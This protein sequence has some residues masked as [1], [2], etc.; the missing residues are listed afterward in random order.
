[1]ITITLTERQARTLADA[2]D[3]Y[4]RIGMGQL[5]SMLWTLKDSYPDKYEEI[6]NADWLISALKKQV[7]GFSKTRAYS[8]YSTNV[9]VAHRNAFD[10]YKQVR[11]TLEQSRG[12]PVLEG[13]HAAAPDLPAGDGGY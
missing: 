8:I 11:H 5:E 4:S 12:E 3:L 9:P 13:V 10:M 1:M 2:L 7:F 6:E